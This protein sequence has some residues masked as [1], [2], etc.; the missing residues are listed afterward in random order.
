MTAIHLEGV[1][2]TWVIG[3]ILTFKTSSAPLKQ[4]LSQSLYKSQ[5]MWLVG[6]SNQYE[7][8]QSSVFNVQVEIPDP[9][10]G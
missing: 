10:L 9:E 7:S 1:T 4:S 8:V 5:H 2:F 3:R 6:W